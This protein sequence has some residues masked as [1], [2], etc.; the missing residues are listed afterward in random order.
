[1]R[2][3]LGMSACALVFFAS[4]LAGAFLAATFIGCFPVAAFCAEVLFFT[5]AFASFLTA[6]FFAN[7]V[8]VAMHHLVRM[9]ARIFRK[10][11]EPVTHELQPLA[12]DVIDAVAALPLV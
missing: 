10:P 11:R 3:R 1:M 2:N 12:I 6:A 8:F 7:R 9:S 4:V 5:G